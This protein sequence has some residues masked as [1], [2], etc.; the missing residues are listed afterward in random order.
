MIEYWISPSNE[1]VFQ[2]DAPARA[3]NLTVQVPRGGRCSFQVH[4]R[5]A[6]TPAPSWIDAKAATR[7]N[8]E[9]RVRRIGYVA[10]PHRN[11]GTPP[12]EIDHYA[13]IPGFVPDPLF[14]QTGQLAAPDLNYGYWITVVVPTSARPGLRTVTV[15]LFA[16]GSRKPFGTLNARIDV[17]AV[18]LAPRRDFPVTHWFYTDALCDWYGVDPFVEAFWPVCDRYL[19]NYAEHGSDTIYVPALT[20][21]LDG[22]K[23][24][25]QLLRITPA[26]DGG[27]RFDWKL[28]KRFVDLARSCG[29]RRFEWPHLFTQW[30]A[31]R[32]IL[33]YR[34]R[35][36]SAE[37]LWPRATPATSPTYRR[38]LEAYLPALKR[39]L[40]REGMLDCSYFHVSDEPHQ[41]HLENYRKARSMLKELAPWMKV[42]DAL[43]NIEFAR[44][45]LT[46]VPVPSIATAI[47]FKE[48]GIP[49]WAYFCCSPRGEYTNRL[50]DTPLPKI[51]AIGWLL[52]RHRFLGFLHW[53]FN[54]WYKSQTRELIDPYLV[55]DGLAW[56]N[57][58]HG[59]TF[60][61]YP[62]PDGP[63]DSIRWEVFAESLQDYTLL[64]TLGVDPDD[65]A[66]APLQD[67]RVFPRDPAWIPC[68]RRKILERRDRSRAPQVDRD[69]A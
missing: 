67:F 66:L 51:R 8:L 1:R 42:M 12:W 28:V 37:P 48:A 40:D 25:T 5:L 64:Q 10:V 15:E 32:A 50:L 68:V 34:D 60:V 54:Y 62:G 22:E 26:G 56:P 55:S 19:R 20:P 44:D 11:T 43:S 27:Y 46:D 69:S 58:A 4:A 7:S 49:S 31:E 65:S 14:P 2:T 59:D 36:G 41:D 38:F 47:E 30:G 23:R 13:D 24:P 52:Y 45:D 33:V 18:A 3:S 9:L 53:G 61:V 63:I 21:S 6:S 16:D 17:S 29:I 35:G 39:F 57:W